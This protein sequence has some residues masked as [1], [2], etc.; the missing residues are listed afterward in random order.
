MKTLRYA[1]RES[2]VVELP[3]SGKQLTLG[4]NPWELFEQWVWKIEAV[5]GPRQ[6]GK[7]TEALARFCEIFQVEPHQAEF[8]L[9]A[10]TEPDLLIEED[11]SVTFTFTEIEEP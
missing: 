2:E 1:A 10:E 4:V 9:R 11:G 8:M 7:R 3:D 6:R 5:S